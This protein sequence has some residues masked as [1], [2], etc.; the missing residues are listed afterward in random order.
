ME[1]RKSKTDVAQGIIYVPNVIIDVLNT[2]ELVKKNL[3]IRYE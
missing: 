3:K 1:I 2:K